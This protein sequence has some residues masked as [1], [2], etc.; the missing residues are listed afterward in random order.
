MIDISY[1]MPC[2]GYLFQEKADYEKV[3]VRG[4]FPLT[5]LCAYALLHI[6]EKVAQNERSVFTFLTSREQESLPR[7][8]GKDEQLWVGIDAIYDYFKPLFKESNDQPQI[9]NEW[10]KADYAL[11]KVSDSNEKRVIKAISVIQMLRREEELPVTD[12]AIRAALGMEETT[13][14]ETIHQ[15]CAQQIVIY[16]SSRGIYAFKN[17]VG[18]DIEKGNCQRDKKSSQS[19]FQSVNI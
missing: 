19:V 7:I 6:S 2:F 10:L 14:Q 8:M 16:R 13:Y 5:P 4:C 12:E 15:L 3:V 9:H 18:L 1:G 11:K 17:N